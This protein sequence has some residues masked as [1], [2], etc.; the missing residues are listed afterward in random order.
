M[1]F[2]NNIENNSILIIPN[3]IKEKL[4]L[5]LNKDLKNIKIMSL[6]DLKKNYYFDYTTES[7]YHVINKYNL[8]FDFALEILNNLYYIE[9]KNY[10]NDKLNF[11]V[12]IKNDLISNNLLT[13]NDIFKEYIKNS[14]KSM[15]GQK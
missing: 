6:N 1:K 13:F 14:I 12:T 10:K 11:H 4:L 15:N 7:I 2:L 3:N 8:T 9:N 5:Y